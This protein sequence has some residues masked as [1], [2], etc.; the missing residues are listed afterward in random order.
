MELKQY[1]GLTPDGQL[2]RNRLQEALAYVHYW[3]TKGKKRAQAAKE[4]LINL[5]TDEGDILLRALHVDR[6]E[7]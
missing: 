4:A 1:P 5:N 3:E 6:K 2:N 7:L